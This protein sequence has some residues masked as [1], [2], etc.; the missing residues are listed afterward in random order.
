LKASDDLKQKA[1]M[2]VLAKVAII[3]TELIE[4]SENQ[5]AE[6]REFVEPYLA[7][8]EEQTEAMEKI[9]GPLD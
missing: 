5:S 4:D 2:I 3:F 6:I 8:V 1:K 9:F 7:K